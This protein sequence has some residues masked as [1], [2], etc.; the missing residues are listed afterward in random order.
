[1]CELLPRGHGYQP[2]E[3]NM[4]PNNR[5]FKSLQI[6]DASFNW[7]IMYS[8]G[9]RL[10]LQNVLNS[11]FLYHCHQHM[12]LTERVSLLNL[13]SFGSSYSGILLQT[14]GK[15]LFYNLFFFFL[16]FLVSFLCFILVKVDLK[17][18]PARIKSILVVFSTSSH[19]DY[20]L[21]LATKQFSQYISQWPCLRFKADN[22][23]QLGCLPQ[24]CS[25]SSFHL[26][27]FIVA[28]FQ[29]LHSKIQAYKE[30]K[31]VLRDKG[32]IMK[33][34]MVLNSQAVFY[35]VPSKNK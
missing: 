18:K 34:K 23:L 12:Y 5:F 15:K 26:L 28:S 10:V 1:M 2:K 33:S 7:A 21:I 30:I 4:V 11:V 24:Q 25:W 22:L 6:S 16:T 27:I 29:P 17:Q 20:Y 32:N 14:F 8:K 3:L 9:H 19:P 13:A 31:S 35:I